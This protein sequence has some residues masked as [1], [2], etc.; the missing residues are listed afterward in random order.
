MEEENDH[1]RTHEPKL[2]KAIL[3]EVYTRNR[4]IHFSPDP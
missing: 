4:L 1:S 2:P 3:Q